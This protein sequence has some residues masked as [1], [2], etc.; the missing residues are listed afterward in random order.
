QYGDVDSATR[1]FS[2]TA[3]KSNYIYTAMF[4]GLISNNMAEKAFD[5]LD[6]ME[7]KPDSFTLAILF[8]ACAEL[9]NDR[10]LKIGRKLLD[11]MPENYRND[12]ITSTSAINM[13]MKFGDIQ[14]AERIFRSNK[15]KDIITY[16]AIIKGN[17]Y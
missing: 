6:E 4:K 12:N 14:S 5:L 1:L 17:T 15:K 9:A 16:N 8:K 10:A 7:I 11:E 3:N 13:L 2:S